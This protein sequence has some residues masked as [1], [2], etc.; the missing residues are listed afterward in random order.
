MDFMMNVKEDIQWNSGNYLHSA[1]I[2]YRL[3]L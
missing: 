3:Q 1:F 2:A